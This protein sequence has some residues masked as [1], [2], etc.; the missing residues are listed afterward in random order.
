MNLSIKNLKPFWFLLIGIA[1]ISMTHMSFG[2]DFFAWFSVAPFLLYLSSTKGWK[3]RL[4]FV[5][6]LIIA[7]S[8]VVLKIITPPIPFLMIFLFSIPISLFHLPAYLIW[9]KFKNHKWS[10]LV[11]PSTL[12]IMEWVQYTFCKLGSYGIFTI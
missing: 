1:T 8:I 9:D 2:V 6:A 12:I 5:I 7:W 10:I 3:S 4:L 11:F